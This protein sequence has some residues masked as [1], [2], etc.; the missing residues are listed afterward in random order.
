MPWS[1]VNWE[2]EARKAANYVLQGDEGGEQHGA[3][4]WGPPETAAIFCRIDENP[5]SETRSKTCI[6]VLKELLAN[7]AIT[8]IAFGLSKNRQAWAVIVE[9][10]ALDLLD[11]IVKEAWEIAKKMQD[12][13]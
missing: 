12:E 1:K 8:P 13:D 6:T 10:N 9:S 3:M 11:A 7:A 2:E 4:R 5:E